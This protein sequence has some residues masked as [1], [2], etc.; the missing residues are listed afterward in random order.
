MIYLPFTIVAMDADAPQQSNHLFIAF[1]YFFPTKHL[2]EIFLQ[3]TLQC[4][5]NVP[6]YP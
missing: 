2:V 6:S 1:V 5:D 4:K 3:I